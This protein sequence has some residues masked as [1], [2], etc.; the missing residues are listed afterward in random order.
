MRKAL[1]VGVND[2]PF[3]ALGGCINDANAIANILETHGDGSPNFDVRLMT[4]PSDV[5]TRASLRKAIE[6]LFS[7][8]PDIALLYFAGHG[9]I[10]STGGYLVTTDAAKYD[11]GVSM[12]ELLLLAN[13]SKAKDKIILLD[14]CHSG[15]CG[16]PTIN[17]AN[18]SQLK[19]GTSVLT[20]SRD[21]E[22]ALEVGGRGVFTSLVVDGLQG[23]AADLRGHVTPGSIYAYVDQALGPWDQRPIFKT[24]VTRFTSIRTITPRVPLEVLRKLIEYFPTPSD[25][26]DLDPSYEDTVK[27]HDPAK[28]AIFKHLQ[29]FTSV[30]LVIPVDEEHMYY[31]AM[32]SK[33]CRLTAL[34]YQYWRLVKEKRL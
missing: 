34:G 31:A 4:S 13:K 9:S 12:D 15:A 11:E 26:H 20:A 17:E 2:Y 30:G 21:S 23:G 32:N 22:S 29:K 3:G 33:S 1:V 14:C 7:G 24:N 25:G 5:V 8:E 27:G 10:T 18:I 19:E 16:T 6:E 28:A